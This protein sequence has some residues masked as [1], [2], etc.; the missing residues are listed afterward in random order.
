MMTP[1]IFS[2]K[3]P[4]FKVEGAEEMG[5][6]HAAEHDNGIIVAIE[7]YD[8]PRGEQEQ[9]EVMI[10]PGASQEEALQ[11]ML[12]QSM[13]RRWRQKMSLRAVRRWCR[14]NIWY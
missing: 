6:V 3:F 10:P 5:L 12:Q 4:R 8:V 14:R 9:L 7:R 2:L 13:C 1:R 11:A